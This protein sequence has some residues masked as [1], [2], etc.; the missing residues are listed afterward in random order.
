MM[1]R[2][3]P[4]EVH[5]LLKLLVLDPKSPTFPVTADLV[6]HWGD[7][8]LV[9]Q[10]LVKPTS[11]ELDHLRLSLNVVSYC[12]KSGYVRYRIYIGVTTTFSAGPNGRTVHG[13]GLRPLACRDCG[14]ETHWGH[15]RL[16]VVWMLCVVR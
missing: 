14:F 1:N 2:C 5:I 6:V 11:R 12:Q 13:I 8:R 16:S 9:G 10:L 15:G 3:V 7:W 4:V